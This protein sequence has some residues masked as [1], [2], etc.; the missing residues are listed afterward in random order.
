MVIFRAFMWSFHWF[1][2][3]CIFHKI[4]YS[5]SYLICIKI[6]KKNEDR[7]E[8][9]RGRE[10][11]GRERYSFICFF[12]LS[13][14]QSFLREML[15]IM[16]FHMD[17]VDL[18][19]LCVT[20]VHY[21]ILVNGLL[22]DTIIPSRGLIQGDPLSPYLFILCAEGLSFL[23]NRAVVQGRW[24]SCKI[25]QG[26]PCVSHLFFADDSLLSFKAN[27]E[28]VATVLE[29]LQ[30]YESASSKSCI[31]FSAHSSQ[32]CR[33]YISHL[34][35]LL[36]VLNIGKYLGFP[37]GIGRNKQEVFSFIESK[38]RHRIGGWGKKMLSRAS[39]EILLKAVAQALPMYTMSLYYIPAT[40]CDRLEKIC[41]KFWWESGVAN[42]MH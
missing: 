13:K 11:C 26:A 1:P 5:I 21:R 28:E 35:N 3:V 39:K 42:G 15:I 6:D 17:F 10:N 34:L 41:N 27:Y 4:S 32:H 14:W 38:L 31:M 37:M 9:K 20:S 12:F 24:S 16:G 7:A 29:C 33:R 25:T 8:C 40:I 2:C 18:I 30:K 23:I 22:S 36:E 19:M